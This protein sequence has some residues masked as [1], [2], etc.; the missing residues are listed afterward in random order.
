MTN[1]EWVDSLSDEDLIDWIYGDMVKIAK[2]YNSSAAG[3]KQWLKEEHRD[4][5]CV[6]CENKEECRY[7]MAQIFPY[8]CNDYKEIKQ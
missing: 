6:K 2:G 5:I 1:R 7:Y 4:P 8:I 3:L